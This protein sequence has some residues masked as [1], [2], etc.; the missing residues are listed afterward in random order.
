MI[1]AGET[2]VAFDELRWLLS[3]CADC[4]DAHLL[5]GELA[6]KEKN[7]IPL[8]RG[9][10]GYAYQLGHRAWRRAGGPTPVAYSQPANR[11]FHEAG[12]SL[13]WCLEKL[14][15]RAMA[16]EIVDTLLLLDPSDP[17][18]VKAWLAQIQD[19]GLPLAGP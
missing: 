11:S 2:E 10:F 6:V 7:D 1:E 14:G 5:L 8:A 12:R 17:L 13:A 3:G 4:L 15:K 9:H 18:S 16:V 19:G